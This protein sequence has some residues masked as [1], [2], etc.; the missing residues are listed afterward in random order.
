MNCQRKESHKYPYPR[1]KV[2][3]LRDDLGRAAEEAIVIGFLCYT[4]R[5]SNI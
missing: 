1:V 3:C 5:K 4:E 2:G